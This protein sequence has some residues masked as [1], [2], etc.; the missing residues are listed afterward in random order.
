M[1]YPL[2]I[3]EQEAAPI[4]PAS[5]GNP[6]DIKKIAYKVVGTLPWVI[7]GLLIATITV[8]LYLR[9]TPTEYKV[10]A[11][12]LVKKETETNVDYN[13]LKELGVVQ[14][15]NDILNQIDIFKSY[16]LLERVVD[17]LKLNIHVRQQ[18]RVTK[19]QLYG[20]DIPFTFKVLKINPDF[21]PSSYQ[22]KLSRNGY[23]ING[24]DINKSLKW[25]DTLEVDYGKL[26]LERNPSV[27]TASDP[28]LLD[29]NTRHT[30]AGYL[31]NSLKADLT[32]DKGGGIV[33]ISMVD[34]LPDRAIEILNTLITIFNDADLADKNIV[35]YRTVKF[36][37]D[38]I[39]SV[40]KE[41][42]KIEAIAEEFKKNN[43]ITD[44]AI[45]GGIFQNEAVNIDGQRIKEYTQ[46]KVLD[47]LENFM[48]NFKGNNEIIPSTMGIGEQSLQTLILQHNN[49][50]VEKQ[51]LEKRSAPSDPHL[52]DKTKQIFDIRD[53]ILRN[54]KLLKKAFAQTVTDLE[55]SYNSIEN[56][57]G[58]LP[59]KERI[60]LGLKRLA[61]VKEELYVYLLKKKEEAQLLLASNINNTRVIDYAT[62]LGSV[63]PNRKQI[64]LLAY[65]IG[66]IVPIGIVLL[67]DFLNNKVAEKKEIE[68]ATTLPIVG[69]LSYVKKKKPHL[70]D[71]RSK[72]P[73]A[74]QFR[75][76]RTNLYF[77]APNKQVKTIM[78]SSFMSGE[79]KSFVS[80]NLANA[81]SVTGAKTVILEFD[82]RNPNF[83]KALN[84]SNDT[85]LSN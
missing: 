41:L 54:I 81:L 32:N 37:S 62:D 57:I 85:G 11:Y 43:R 67:K 76:L 56:R 63:T 53:N 77:A 40:N 82:L 13:V 73:I 75:L 22:L 46:Y 1:S 31:R 12:V 51:D 66:L 47:A 52:L 2:G 70:I 35:T 7:I 58:T 29:F 68:A 3:Q 36:L 26:V 25:G 39:D 19:S 71:I 23:T 48:S 69:E 5:A 72:S 27:K 15:V 45:Q 60:L 14:S 74:E 10:A 50:V 6:L 17:S 16:T 80:L 33:E 28:F 78:L 84:V 65:L 59:E 64:K 79:G 83:S 38:R 30:E 34:Q 4:Q 9:Y 20:S 44:I 42:Q 24:K 49:L 55:S 8:R 21:N 61:S 18:G